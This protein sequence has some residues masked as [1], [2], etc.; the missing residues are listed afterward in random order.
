MALNPK[1]KA[2][3]AKINE[4]TANYKAYV[5]Q[6]KPSTDKRPPTE[7]EEI[8]ANHIADKQKMSQIY[9]ELIQFNSKKP[10][11]LIKN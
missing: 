10:N 1:A 8:F 6:M 4:T 11:N 3:K 7:R 5:Q 2:R 9:K